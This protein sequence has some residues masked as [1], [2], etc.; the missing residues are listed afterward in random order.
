MIAREKTAIMA[1]YLNQFYYKDMFIR[2]ITTQ[3]RHKM[4]IEE[5]SDLL[6]EAWTDGRLSDETLEYVSAGLI[7]LHLIH[8]E[9]NWKLEKAM[10][11]D[12]YVTMESELTTS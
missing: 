12:I 9:L 2:K 1:R 4:N 6:H 5:F 10:D 7:P 8:R 3:T 11:G